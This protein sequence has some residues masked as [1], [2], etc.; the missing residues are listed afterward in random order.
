MKSQSFTKTTTQHNGLES[1]VIVTTNVGGN[2][3]A[4]RDAVMLSTVLNTLCCGKTQPRFAPQL[5]ALT[6]SSFYNHKL[7]KE[8][9]NGN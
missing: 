4:R 9:K 8:V 6:P 1:S 7:T 2:W 3:K 5:A